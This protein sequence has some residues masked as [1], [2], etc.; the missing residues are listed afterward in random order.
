M[1]P[2]AAGGHLESAAGV[3]G[4]MKVVLAMQQGVIPPH[5]HFRNPS[6]QMDWNRLPLRVTAEATRWPV[7]DGHPPLA[8]V[9][10]FG[11]SGTNAHVL[12]QGHPAADGG[13]VRAWSGRTRRP[14]PRGPI[15]VTL[16]ERASEAP[17]SGGLAA[18]A[19]R[20]LPLSGKS[21]EALRRGARVPALARRPRR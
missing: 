17:V 21:E 19:S 20:F 3:A 7:R 1:R 15:A 10:G 8:G 2:T 9:S 18:R 12:L 11:W 13:P 16:P 4:V 5:L 14:D 6:P